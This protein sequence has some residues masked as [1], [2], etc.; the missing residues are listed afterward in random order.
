MEEESVASHSAGAP[1]SGDVLRHHGGEE[2][3]EGLVARPAGAHQAPE[4]NMGSRTRQSHESPW[5]KSL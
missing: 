3:R 4:H 2:H 5:K 1:R